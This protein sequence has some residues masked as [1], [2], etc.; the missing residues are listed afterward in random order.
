MQPQ[1]FA[2]LIQVAQKVRE[3][4]YDNES[5]SYKLSYRDAATQACE[6]SAEAW[7]TPV[8]LLITCAWNDIQVWAEQN[9]TVKLPAE[10]QPNVNEEDMQVIQIVYKAET[11]NQKFDNRASAFMEGLGGAFEGSGFGMG[12]RDIGFHFAKNE[13]INHDAMATYLYEIA[14]QEGVE[15]LHPKRPA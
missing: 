12:E 10:L 11:I 1:R 8:S 15:L 3:E 7:I 6:G 13:I 14:K 9:V 2:E 5:Q 4:S